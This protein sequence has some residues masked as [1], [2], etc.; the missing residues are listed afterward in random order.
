[1]SILINISNHPSKDWS[2]EQKKSWDNIIDIPFPNVNPFADHLDIY[3][4][5]G[6]LFT[7]IV[8]MLYK[9]YRKGKR[10]YT[11]KE[12]EKNIALVK[13]LFRGVTFHVAGELSLFFALCRF[14]HYHD[15]IIVI[16]CTERQV[17]EII[18][19]DGS[20]EKRAFFVFRQWREIKKM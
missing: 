1:M 6:D 2:T 7:S 12:P 16:A 15:G 9:N 4:M 20:V 13:K 5:A 3:D 11:S 18:Q 17:T 14:I 8:H 10:G 19:K